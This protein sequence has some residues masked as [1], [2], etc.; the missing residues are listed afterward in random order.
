MTVVSVPQREPLVLGGR[1]SSMSF[2][3]RGY[4]GALPMV[5]TAPPPLPR[6]PDP[7]ALPPT[8]FLP[9]FLGGD[10]PCLTP[11]PRAPAPLPSCSLAA[12]GGTPRAAPKKRRKKKVR[13]SPSGQLPSR[14]HQYQQRRPSLEGGRSPAPGHCGAQQVPDRAQA[15]AWVPAPA[16]ATR[17]EEASPLLGPLPPAA[18]GQPSFRRE[19]LKSKMGKSEKIAIPHGQLV[20]GIPLCEQPKIN[21]QKNKYNLPLTKITSAKR[22]ENN[23]W[24]DSVSSDI[25]QKQEKK[26]FKNTENIK[27]K[28]LKKS[29]FLTEVSQKEN[30]AGAKFSDPPSPSV[31]PKPPSHWMGTTIENSNQN[32]ELMA[33]HLKTLL[34]VQT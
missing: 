16:A 30:Y 20:H 17:T 9:H 7:R 18:P 29:S 11:Q 32:R 6:I 27:N 22:N 31:L 10:G 28:H 14:F 8:L 21:R 25:I 12:A 15:A 4:F 2:S 19:V 33:V 5:T 13:T 34:K 24:Q 23:F 3:T 26:P 1:L